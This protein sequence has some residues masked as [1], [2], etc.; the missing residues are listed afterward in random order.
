M[1]ANLVFLKSK[2]SAIFLIATL[3]VIT[4]CAQVADDTGSQ[5]EQLSDSEPA[6]DDLTDVN[7]D[8]TIPFCGISSL[9]LL[10]SSLKEYSGTD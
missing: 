3:L 6:N 7:L 5:N 9:G 8:T 4:G 1:S 10:N 2:L